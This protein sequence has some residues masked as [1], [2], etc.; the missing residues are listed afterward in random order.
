MGDQAQGTRFRGAAPQA[1]RLDKVL[2]GALPELSRA[3]VAALI[4]AGAAQVGGEVVRRP[5]Q[6]IEEGVEIALDLPPPAP[7]ELIPEPLPLRLIYQDGDLVVVDKAP[8]MVVHPGAGHQTG[9]LVHALLHHV[10]DLSGIG[11]VERPGIVHRL[12]RGTSGLLVVAKHD[13]AHRALAEQFAVHSARRRYLALVHGVPSASAATI[14]SRLARHP[15]DRIRFASTDGGEHGKEAVTHWR[16]LGGAQGIGLVECKLETG[17]TH[18]IRVHLCE[19]GFPIVGDPLYRRAGCG[20]PELL[21]RVV[22][23]LSD[24]PLLHA[25][26]LELDHPSTGQR[27]R[28]IAAP[29]ADF[30]RALHALGISG[31]L[32]APIRAPTGQA[33]S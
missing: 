19:A 1:G 2:A 25:W 22:S 18:Q 21:Q 14:R 5:G 28:W 10:R 8:G 20:L 16:R 11:G 24:R 17:R 12:D 33:R 27:Q 15:S 13:Q 31:A 9:T 7:S 32:P 6:R 23:E 3:R 4:K 30:L 26:S 29:P